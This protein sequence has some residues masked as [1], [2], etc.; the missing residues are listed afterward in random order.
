MDAVLEF[1]EGGQVHVER[2]H[3]AAKITEKRLNIVTA[4]E[5]Y[6]V[7]ELIALATSK[8][9]LLDDGLRKVAWPILI[10]SDGT[11]GDEASASSEKDYSPHK[12]EQQIE[13]DVNRS[14]VYYPKGWP[15]YQLRN[16][17][18]GRQNVVGMMDNTIQAKQSYHDIAQVLLLV[19]EQPDLAVSAL[20]RISLFRIRDYMLPSLTPSL[21]HLD[22]ITE[23]LYRHDKELS[24]RV[25]RT[26]PYFALAATLTL[27]A[28]DIEQYSDI[29][30]LFDFIL[31]HEPVVTIYLYAAIIT[32]RRDEI[33]SI[34]PSEPEMIHFK[35]SKLPQPLNL[36]G[37]IEQTMAL[38]T[39]FPPQR[40]P[41]GCWSR[42]PR[43][44]VLKT[45]RDLVVA[46]R[47]RRRAEGVTLYKEQ[48]KDLAKE[49]WRR[50]S[51]K[52]IWGYRKP[53]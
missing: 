39:A 30:R 35:L 22:L 13:L 9:G 17:E 19:L 32:M 7:E 29:V 33:L 4:C 8:G 41:H 5:K 52:V 51:L 42:I 47:R 25:S 2:D 46:G 26:Q 36:E 1:S 6:D 34:P 53:A 21:K 12:D 31:S 15:Q 20:E 18:N 11:E 48:M 38:Y 10:G 27:Y 14:F 37:L 23:I 45:S 28:H 24:R 44:S 50:K 40:L 49:E 16:R 43:N 3:A